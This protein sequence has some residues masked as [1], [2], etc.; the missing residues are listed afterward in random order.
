MRTLRTITNIAF[1][2]LLSQGV[3]AMEHRDNPIRQEFVANINN[4]FTGCMCSGCLKGKISKLIKEPKFINVTFNKGDLI[5]ICKNIEQPAEVIFQDY[6]QLSQRARD[7]TFPKKLVTHLL[8]R[9]MKETKI[10]RALDPLSPWHSDSLKIRK[11]VRK[12]K[13]VTLGA[14]DMRGRLDE[15]ALRWLK[16]QQDDFN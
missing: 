5:A 4:G 3:F 16:E 12:I 8:D 11:R 14:L 2:F 10:K 9:G 15:E 7:S 6:L 1:C 13:K